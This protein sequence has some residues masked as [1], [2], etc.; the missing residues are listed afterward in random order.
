[1]PPLPETTGPFVAV[2]TFCEKVIREHDN[3]MSLM[4]VVDQLNVNASGPDPPTQLPPVPINL[5]LAL[6]LRRGTARG[7]HPLKLRP[8]S[9]SGEQHEAVELSV[10]FTGDEESGANIIGDLSGFAV[11]EEGLWWFDVLFG[12]AETRIARI[13]LRVNY[14][15]QRTQE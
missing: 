10:N 12:D 9:P 2:A 5:S 4:R 6:V 11:N 7:R 13:P 3:V 14:H 1:V 15:P 8:E